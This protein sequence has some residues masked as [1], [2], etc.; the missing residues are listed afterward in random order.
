MKKGVYALAALMVL[1]CGCG[2]S[3]G[4]AAAKRW[5]EMST[6]IWRG[7]DDPD[8]RQLNAM[9]NIVPDIRKAS[10]EALSVQAADFRDFGVETP[11]FRGL[12]YP[13]MK[14]HVKTNVRK[15]H[16][17]I[18]LLETGFILTSLDI[19]V[20]MDFPR[21]YDKMTAD[22][23]TAVIDAFFEGVLEGLFYGTEH[24]IIWVGRKQSYIR[25]EILMKQ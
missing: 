12:L 10:V 5:G 14:K 8:E 18:V 3:E 16:R 20:E 4:N 15:E 24:P 17:T 23:K 11:T 21:W 13:I 6:V 7:F 22:K 19:L 9:N 2:V 1:A 25:A